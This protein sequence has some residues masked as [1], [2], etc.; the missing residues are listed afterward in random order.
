[1]ALCA[2]LRVREFELTRTHDL[3]A[4]A[5]VEFEEAR[6]ECVRGLPYAGPGRAPKYR[7]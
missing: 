4:G 7:T 3:Q 1:M 6:L 2:G 5:A